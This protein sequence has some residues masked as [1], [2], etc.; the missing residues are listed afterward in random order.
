MEIIKLKDYTNEFVQRMPKYVLKK[1]DGKRWTTIDSS[2]VPLSD[3]RLRGHLSGKNAVGCIG[4]WYPGHA[5]FDIDN[6]DIDFVYEVQE[7]LNLNDHNSLLCSSES[8]D[9]YHLIVRPVYRKKLPTLRLL[10]EIMYPFAR[11]QGIEA[12]PTAKKACRLPFGPSQMILN[13][14]G[15]WLDKW[16][17]KLYWYEKLDEYDLTNVP[18]STPD[19]DLQYPQSKGKISAYQQ[20][21]EYLEHGLQGPSTREQGQFHIIYYLWRKNVPLSTTIETVCHWIKT[22]HNGYSKDILNNPREVKKHITRQAKIIYSRYDLPD[23]AHNL[24]VGYVTKEDLPAILHHMDGSLPKSRTLFNI[25]KYCYP[26]RLRKKITVH[27]DLLIEWSSRDTYTKR[28]SELHSMGILQRGDGY[29][30]GKKSK[31]LVLKWHYG[32]P[33]KAILVDERSPDTL[34][35][36]ISACMEPEETRALLKQAGVDRRNVGQYTKQIYE[37]NVIKT[38]NI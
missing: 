36:T 3:N 17:K 8:P 23:D 22:K 24:Y 12:Y 13:E 9:S 2:L 25:V 37:G 5:I 31:D 26:R 4:R 20:G 6:K 30:I 28:L 10:N 1:S 35:E 27:S 34:D 14:G 21:K 33:E 15:E 7:K 11:S 18:Y 29:I 38:V 19:L 32:D 16:Q